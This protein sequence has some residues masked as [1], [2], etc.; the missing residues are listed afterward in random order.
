MR[1]N[2]DT[3]AEVIHTRE[4]IGEE[5]R[6][7]LGDMTPS[8][9]RVARTLLATYPTAG[10]E[11]LP[12][13]AEAADVTGP[14]VLRFVRKIGYEGYPDF[15]RSLRLEVQA[16]TE[17]LYSLY[18][19]RVTTQDDLV[20]NS[21]LDAFRRALEETFSAK[22]LEDDL[23]DVV[24][25][26]S[27]PKYHLWFVGGR[28]SHL[29]ATYL[30]LLLRRLRPGCS[31]VGEAP[32]DRVLDSLELSRKSVLC[33]FDY[34][35]YQPDTIAVGKV[36][37]ERGAAVIVF[38]DPWLSPAVEF[39][40]RVFISHADSASPFDSML[41]GFAL[42]ELIAAKV[43]TVTGDVGRE[44]VGELEA[45][46]IGDFMKGPVIEGPGATEGGAAG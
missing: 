24:S 5:V 35:R 43:V 13:L 9:R 16:R 10:L 6:D 19:S 8:E 32:D 30:Y 39:A 42:A 20:L 23:A 11:S 29:L 1:K 36:A 38:T 33:L 45:V 40:R 2:P 18:A 15:Q 41:G 27:D 12:Q 21:S 17:G 14:T 34:R 44:R 37:V 26:L 31:M 25:L 46:G 3:G 4:T 28:F 22:T 7:R